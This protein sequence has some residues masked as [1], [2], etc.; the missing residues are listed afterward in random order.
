MLD[1]RGTPSEHTARLKR[2]CGLTLRLVDGETPVQFPKGWADE[3]TAVVGTGHTA[4]MQFGDFERKYMVT[5]PGT[6]KLEL[7][8]I[9]GFVKPPVLEVDIRPGEFIER[10]VALERAH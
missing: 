4:L 9:S 7:P 10:V 6:Y 2:G 8:A 5:E 3:P 1:L